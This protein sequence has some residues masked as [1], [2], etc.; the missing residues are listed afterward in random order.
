MIVCFFCPIGLF[1][2]AWTSQPGVQWAGTLI[3]ILIFTVSLL[4]CP[5]SV[6]QTTRLRRDLQLY[7]LNKFADR[8]F[9]PHPVHLPLPA[10]HLPAVRRLPLRG[11]RLCPLHPG[12]RRHPLLHPALP[13]PRRAKGRLAARGPLH[14]LRRRCVCAV[15]LRRE[16]E[17]QEQVCCEVR[18]V[19]AMSFIGEAATSSFRRC[20]SM[21][22]AV[23]GL[24][25][26]L[27]VKMARG[28]AQELH[29]WHVML[30]AKIPKCQIASTSPF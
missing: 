8:H 2:F 13:Q 17:G 4:F 28:C 7:R 18:R 21:A 26:A 3:G 10:P 11:Q 23:R 30:Y 29:S 12:L 6:F 24:V 15:L 27:H 20:S 9:H 14:R 5:Y 25:G 1:I 19:S 22:L 16:A